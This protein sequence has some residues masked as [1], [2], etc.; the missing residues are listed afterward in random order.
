VLSEAGL[1]ETTF[2]PRDTGGYRAETIVTDA[3]GAVVGNAETGWSSDPAAE[4]FRTLIPNKALLEEIAK[5][6]GGEMVPADKLDAFAAA[7]PYRQVPIT[8][9]WTTPFWHQPWIFLFALA[10]FA[11]EWGLRRWKGL[12]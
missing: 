1:Y 4:E 11:I 5:K 6:T 7:L 3:T 10:C 8:E 9:S 2:V 12:V